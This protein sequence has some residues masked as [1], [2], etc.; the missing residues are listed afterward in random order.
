[1]NILYLMG[2]LTGDPAIT[3]T[4]DGKNI[5]KFRIAVNRKYHKEGETEA[6]FFNCVSFGKVAERLDRLNVI[7]GTKLLLTCE[8]RNNNYTDKEGTKHYE[9]QIIVSDFE[10]CEKKHN[11]SVDDSDGFVNVSDGIAEEGLPFE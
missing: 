9:N 11:Q 5:A 8:L 6:D 4:T 7:K 3:S 10:F 1:M 2:R